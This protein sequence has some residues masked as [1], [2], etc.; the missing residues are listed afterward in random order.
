LPDISENYKTVQYD[1]SNEGD[2]TKLTITQDNNSSQEEAN[3]SK[4]N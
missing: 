3:H 2:G 1:L 4:Q